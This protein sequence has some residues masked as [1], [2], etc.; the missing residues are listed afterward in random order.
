VKIFDQ[1]YVDNLSKRAKAGSRL[2]QLSNIHESYEDLCQRMVNALE[3]NSY[4]PLQRHF[5]VPKNEL[6]VALRGKMAFV[7]FDESGGVRKF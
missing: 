4:I 1:L 5:T 3:P 2:R 7:I 6:M